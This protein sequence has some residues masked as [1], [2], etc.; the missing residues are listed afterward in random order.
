MAYSGLTPLPPTIH[1]SSTPLSHR[2]AHTI[3]SSFLAL[4]ELDPSLRP[5]SVLSERGP[6]SS[7][8]A[9]NPSLALAHLGRIKLGIEGKRS[10]TTTG[11]ATSYDETE[12]MEFWGSEGASGGVKWKRKFGDGD[13]A[14]RKGKKARD[15]M[16]RDVQTVEDVHEAGEPALVSIATA[17]DEDEWQDRENY[18][19][20]QDNDEVDVGNT[21]RNAGARV[22]DV[23]KT[24]EMEGLDGEIVDTRAADARKTDEYVVRR[25]GAIKVDKAERKK[26]KKEKSKIEKK[27]A[28]PR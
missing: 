25:S 19:L 14:V 5:D 8:N 12:G 18:D 15:D 1:H 9:A 24:V 26:L 13:E 21:W 23:E 20:A 27:T 17:H 11:A 10:Q 3:L 16:T 2:A 28:R 22:E 4:A 6:T 7:S